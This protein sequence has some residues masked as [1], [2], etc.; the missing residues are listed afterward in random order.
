VALL[1][2]G[3]LRPRIAR[4]LPL[5]DIAA[6]HELVEAGTAI[7]TVVVEPARG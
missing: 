6:A 4:R 3:M 7:G 1:E 5:R 2:R